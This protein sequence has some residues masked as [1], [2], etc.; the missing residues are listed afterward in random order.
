MP[1]PTTIFSAR[2]LIAGTR[3][4]L[5]TADGDDDGQGHAALAGRTK[6]AGADVLR[7]KLDVRVGHDDRMVIRAAQGLDALAV[8]DAG[9]LDDVGDRGGAD[10]GDG[11]DAGVGEDVGDEVAVTG[12]DVEQ[13]VGQAGFLV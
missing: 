4:L 10:E 1:G 13:A 2:A 3:L 5:D 9:V 12:D 7:G 11:V 6:G 8:R